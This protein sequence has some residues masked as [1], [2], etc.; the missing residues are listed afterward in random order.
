MCPSRGLG[1]GQPIADGAA[2]QVTRTRMGR[3]EGSVS[4]GYS[5]AGKEAHESASHVPR[6]EVPMSNTSSKHLH[7]V[8]AHS[9]Q[10]GEGFLSASKP[11]AKAGWEGRAPHA[12]AA[13]HL[14]GWCPLKRAG[15]AWQ[16]ARDEG[17]AQARAHCFLQPGNYGRF[18]TSARQPR[19]PAPTCSTN[20]DG[21]QG[22]TPRWDGDRAGQEAASGSRRGRD[23]GWVSL[24]RRCILTQEKGLFRWRWCPPLP[25]LP[26][27]QEASLPAPSPAPGQA[28]AT[29]TLTLRL[30]TYELFAFLATLS[31]CNP[32][33]WASW[34]LLLLLMQG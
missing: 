14:P 23:A 6:D 3:R 4:H 24:G 10:W 16:T 26:Q 34:S 1:L 11:C 18:Y 22:C 20:R 12:G 29:A 28:H 33:A 32:G 7:Q 8:P 21:R 25:V 15:V 27:H 9:R 17:W 30:S 2:L 5:W 19:G 13:P 31:G